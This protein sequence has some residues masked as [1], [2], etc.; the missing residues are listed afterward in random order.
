MS[1]LE[2]EVAKR[3]KEPITFRL[4]EDDHEYVFTP[5]KSA[6]MLMPLIDP[7]ENNNG[8]EMTKATFDW[9]GDGLSEEDNKRI[10]DRLRDRDDDLDIELL[11]EVIQKLGEKIN[12]DRPTG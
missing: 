12:G 10:Q 2:F 4:G 1:D 11:S 3:R 8:L 6:I 5:P 7:S 9:L